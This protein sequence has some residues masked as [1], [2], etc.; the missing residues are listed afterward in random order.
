MIFAALLVFYGWGTW[1]RASTWMD[2]LTFWRDAVQKA[3]NKARPHNNLGEQYSKLGRLDDAISEYKR[4]L[5]ILPAF[6]TARN[7]LGTAYT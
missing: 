3:P 7:N 1:Q 4:A 5:A 6:E 2:P